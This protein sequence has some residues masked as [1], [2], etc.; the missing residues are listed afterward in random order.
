VTKLTLQFAT[1]LFR[2]IPPPSNPIGD[3]FDPE[4]DEPVMEA[5]WPHLQVVYEF[6]LRFIESPD[7]NVA[8]AKPYI[9][10]K[11]VLQVPSRFCS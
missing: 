9:D 1:N 11:F 5:A 10:T 3:V 8:A 2:P 6:F 4:E 7:L